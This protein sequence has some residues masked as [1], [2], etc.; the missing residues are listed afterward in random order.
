[1]ANYNLFDNVL[2][3]SSRNTNVKNS[4]DISNSPDKQ[5]I[6]REP[7]KYNMFDD[8]LGDSTKSI[9]AEEIY[10]RTKDHELGLGE[11]FFLGLKDTYR[12][13]KQMA[14]VDLQNMAR[15]QQRIRNLLQDGDGLARA[16]YF[17]GLNLDPAP[18]DPNEFI[19]FIDFIKSSTLSYSSLFPDFNL[20]NKSQALKS[21]PG[22]SSSL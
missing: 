13:V 9:A 5:L 3:E 15:D 19:S 7:N 12:G 20:S 10:K 8:L 22:K 17:G 18:A 14:G 21:F 16:A 1:M 4:F 11:A 2:S 6:L